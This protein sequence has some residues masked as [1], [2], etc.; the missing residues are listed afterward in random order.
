M[1][2]ILDEDRF[3]N[4]RW[5]YP[6]TIS[7]DKFCRMSGLTK[8]QAE[9]IFKELKPDLVPYKGKTRITRE[10]ALALIQYAPLKELARKARK[11]VASF[12]DGGE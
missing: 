6:E 12:K 1:D 8:E 4:N 3:E 11:R 7:L 2:D 5:Q 9:K 10:S